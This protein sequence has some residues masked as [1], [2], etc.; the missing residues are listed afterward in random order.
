M[1]PNHL[2]VIT[3]LRIGY[4]YLILNSDYLGL[5]NSTF[6]WKFLHVHQPGDRPTFGRIKI[7][8]DTRLEGFHKKGQCT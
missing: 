4:I 7:Y 5:D 1:V 8:C 3:D 2:W 6:D